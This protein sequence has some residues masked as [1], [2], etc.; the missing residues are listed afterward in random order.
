VLIASPFNLPRGETVKAK[1]IASNAV[2]DSSESPA[3][4]AGAL[5]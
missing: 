5:I 1:V 2:G 4:A 3:N